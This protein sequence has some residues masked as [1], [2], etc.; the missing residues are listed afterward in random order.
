MLS[1]VLNIIGVLDFYFILINE[2]SPVQNRI[3]KRH[4]QI[5]IQ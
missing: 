3:P 5:K 2:I 1:I 4:R